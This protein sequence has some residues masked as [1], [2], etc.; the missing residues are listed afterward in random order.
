MAGRFQRF[1]KQSK[2]KA[3]RVYFCPSCQCEFSAVKPLSGK[4]A[5]KDAVRRCPVC[6]NLDTLYFASKRECLRY[7]ELKIAELAGLISDIELQPKFPLVPGVEYRADF[8]YTDKRTGER[9]V[10]DAKGVETPE[11]K[12]KRK[13]MAHF[14]PSITIQLC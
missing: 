6:A 2:Y 1:G 14:Y 8:A 12:I 5:D 9:V 4:K 7:R 11:F 13:L 3:Q 10:S